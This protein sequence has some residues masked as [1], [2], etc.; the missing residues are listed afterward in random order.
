MGRSERAG[1]V[2]S[3]AT[4]SAGIFQTEYDSQIRR[5]LDTIDGIRAYLHSDAAKLLPEVVVVGDQ[6]SG[7]SSVLESISEVA[8]PRGS[9]LVTR[10]PLQ[11]ALRQGE[12]HAWIEYGDADNRIE[13][14]LSLAEIPDAIEEA[15]EKLAGTNKGIVNKL[16]HLKVQRPNAPDLTSIDLPGIVRVPVGDQPRDIEKQIK[17][18]I[19]EHATDANAPS[20]QLGCVG[21][22]NRSQADLKNDV[23]A[24]EMRDNEAAFFASHSE[25]RSLPNSCKGLPALVQQLVFLQKQSIRTFLPG[26][27]QQCLTSLYRHFEAN[28]SAR[29]DFSDTFDKQPALRMSP[30]LE[31]M[32]TTHIDQASPEAY[33]IISTVLPA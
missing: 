29:Y 27:K 12:E 22:M 2:D 25:L 11:M 14:E 5:C 10:C 28:A 9:N 31:E 6:S 19:T 15:T 23:T 17:D 7:K 4:K 32:A 13:K 1:P 20:L 18:L 3:G 21:V 8:L 24:E 26:F 30:R 16:I 33:L